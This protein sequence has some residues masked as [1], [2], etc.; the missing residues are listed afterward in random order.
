[1]ESIGFERERLQMIF[2]SAAEGDR[3]R[4]LCQEMDAKIRELGPNPLKKLQSTIPT[5]K[6]VV[7][8]A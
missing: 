4:Q 1:M 2:V 8:T 5:K 6:S 3:W 7:K